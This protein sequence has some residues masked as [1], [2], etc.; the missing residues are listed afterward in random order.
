MGD[1]AEG[2]DNGVEHEE[3][4]EELYGEGEEGDLL[5]GEEA[6]EEEE[7]EGQDVN[8][9]IEELAKKQAALKEEAAKLDGMMKDLKGQQGQAGGEAAAAGTV[10]AVDENSM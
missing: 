7:E 10:P 4:D 8:A 6:E 1:V 5:E 9:Q 2:K 3:E